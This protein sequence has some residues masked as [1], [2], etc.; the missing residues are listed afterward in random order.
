MDDETSAGGAT[1][2]EYQPW[3]EP[4]VA[5]PAA[6]RPAGPPP[7]VGPS[8]GV[9][10]LP[11]AVAGVPGIPG[12]GR[13]SPGAGGGPA[14]RLPAWL[15]VLWAAALAVLLAMVAVGVV[16]SA[17]DRGPMAVGPVWSGELVSFMAPAAAG[18]SAIVLL[19]TG[20][21]DRGTPITRIAALDPATGRERWSE[22]ARVFSASTAEPFYPLV[23][24]D[25]AT[26]VWVRP[27]SADDANGMSVVAA[28]ADT[29]E[30]RWSY[31]QRIR[32]SSPPLLCQ[33]ESAICLV[34]GDGTGP[35]TRTVLDLGT[36]EVRVETQFRDGP[37]FEEIGENLFWSREGSRPD[38]VSRLTAVADDGTERWT[39]PTTETFGETAGGLMLF[40]FETTRQDDV[41]V[42]V[43]H[44][45]FGGIYLERD[46]SR[47]IDEADRNIMVGL[48]AATGE[49]LWTRPGATLGCVGIP[50]DPD[51]PVRCV[52]RGAYRGEVGLEGPADYGVTL[53]GFDL[54][55]GRATWSWDA[56]NALV[57]LGMSETRLVGLGQAGDAVQRVGDT[58]YALRL[59]GETVVLDLARG[60]VSGEPPATGWCTS[61][62]PGYI[63]WPYPC[64]LDQSDAAP[65]APAE[66]GGALVG[67]H[68]VWLDKGG[69]V[70]GGAIAR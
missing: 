4:W 19:R 63:K 10:G 11:G 23:A 62:N 61:Y 47:R 12:A 46:P 40:N 33:E 41:Y 44:H 8:D 42:A 27:L 34:S 26:V 38:V 18:G 35:S 25:G 54:E 21:D 13:W 50:F 66:P 31:G 1:S 49:R 16:L 15:V 52:F 7:A 17:R 3:A 65:P 2:A 14:R 51:H 43:A 5:E 32:V 56:G 9:A 20:E 59:R 69:R 45:A 24:E 36:G 60:L 64:A 6:G 29:G 39:K 68:Y 48:S 53:E 67:D 28:D 55:T 70:H 37:Y 30:Q 22:P 57:L 58:H